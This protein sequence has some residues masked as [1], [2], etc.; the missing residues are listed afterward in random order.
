[1][2]KQP[3]TATIELKKY[4]TI[5]ENY[6]ELPDLSNVLKHE[7]GYP[8]TYPTSTK[9]YNNVREFDGNYMAVDFTS[10]GGG[11]TQSQSIE[12]TK[13]DFSFITTKAY[14]TGDSYPMEHACIDA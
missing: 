13:D 10:A 2:P 1:M 12:M 9:G 14:P 8:S 3:C 4:K 5:A 7:V 6:S 11:I